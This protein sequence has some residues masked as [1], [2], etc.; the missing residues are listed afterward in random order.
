MSSTAT[1]NAKEQ[2]A[3]PQIA[4]GPR[5]LSRRVWDWGKNWGQTLIH[6]V[7]FWRVA[8]LA[9]LVVA[10]V[11]A[12]RVPDFHDRLLA[13]GVLFAL[14][15]LLI[16]DLFIA[17]LNLPLLLFYTLLWGLLSLTSLADVLLFGRNLRLKQNRIAL[18]VLLGNVAMVAAIIG[19]WWVLD[20]APPP[21]E[22]AKPDALQSFETLL[23]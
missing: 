22:P 4:A 21:I 19:L 11:Y 10:G 18:W 3:E 5:C 6:L 7:W 14:G 8:V 15:F 16:L 9:L 1:L 12:F 13:T 2:A 20:S 23:H 17:F